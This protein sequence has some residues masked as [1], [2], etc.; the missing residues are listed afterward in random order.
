MTERE[1]FEDF[2]EEVY[3]VPVLAEDRNGGGYRD[4]IL[5]AGW[6]AWQSSRRQALEEAA[7]VAEC[8]A[9]GEE[10]DEYYD[11]ATR[12]CAAAIRYLAKQND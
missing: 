10:G 9:T 7:D 12:L 5:M 4:T 1:L 3:G 8:E 6:A 2:C 11:S